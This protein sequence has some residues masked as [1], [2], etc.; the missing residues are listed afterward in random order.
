MTAKVSFRV[1]T[2]F[3]RPRG[4]AGITQ[5]NSCRLSLGDALNMVLNEIPGEAITIDHDGFTGDI[6]TIV[7]DWPKVPDEIRYGAM[8]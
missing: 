8:R 3:K 2:Y 1:T 6:V 5:L 7:I 4:E